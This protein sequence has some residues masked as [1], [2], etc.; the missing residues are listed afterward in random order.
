MGEGIFAVTLAEVKA[1]DRYAYVLDGEGPFPDPASRSQPDGVHGASQIIDPSPFGW[2]DQGWRGVRLQDATIYELH[3]GTFTAA[4]TFAGVTERLPYL[5]DL[6]VT[7]VELM[8]VG[9][10]RSVAKADMVNNDVCPEI[11]VDPDS[12][13]VRIDG[14][15]IEQSPATELPMAQRYFLF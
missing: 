12:F 2:S 13:E 1:G 15:V 6:G 10:C 14:E 11:R 8:P 5:A 4:G 7:V 3:V 9:D